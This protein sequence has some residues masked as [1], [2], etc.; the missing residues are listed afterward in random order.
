[1]QFNSSWN[2]VDLKS[3]Q[4]YFSFMWFV[5]T[6]YL[7]CPFFSLLHLCFLIF[8]VLSSPPIG[9]SPGILSSFVLAEL[10]WSLYLFVCLLPAASLFLF[11]EKSI[12]GSWRHL[13]YVVKCVAL[14]KSL[15]C[16]SRFCKQGNLSTAQTLWIE[17]SS[18]NRLGSCFHLLQIF[19]QGG[20]ISCQI[21]CSALFVVL[22]HIRLLY[23]IFRKRNQD[24]MDA[25]IH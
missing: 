5:V 6:S 10:L 24:L 4:L 12:S 21:P 11:A 9:L 3:C 18:A 13:Q 16:L 20:W 1:M 7:P 15:A 25:S 17:L 23:F 2:C 22:L 14:L 19:P 8:C